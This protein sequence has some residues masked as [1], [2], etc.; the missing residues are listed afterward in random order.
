MRI[1]S[2]SFTFLY[3]VCS[4]YKNPSGLYENRM[5]AGMIFGRFL[6]IFCENASAKSLY[7]LNTKSNLFMLP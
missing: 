3:I 4:V 2:R 1:M 5:S 6:C 7:N